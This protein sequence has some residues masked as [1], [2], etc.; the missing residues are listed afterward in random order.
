[1]YSWIMVP[2]DQIHIAEIDLPQLYAPVFRSLS[3]SAQ[4][5]D[6]VKGLPPSKNDAK[7]ILHQGGRM[8]W[9]GDRGDEVA[10][11]RPA[12]QILFYLIAAELVAKIADGFEGKYKSGKYGFFYAK[13]R[14]AT[15]TGTA[16]ISRK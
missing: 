1:M 13:V 3:E 12:F 9:L 14:K 4:F 5:C 16:V 10:S 8:V 6:A 15:R 11:G 7:V 2:D